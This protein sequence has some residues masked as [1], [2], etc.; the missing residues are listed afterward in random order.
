MRSQVEE[1]SKLVTVA[2]KLRMCF[3]ADPDVS[4]TYV[5]QFGSTFV[6]GSRA[7]SRATKRELGSS[8]ENLNILQFYY[9]A[10]MQIE[11]I[12]FWGDQNGTCSTHK[13]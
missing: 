10:G 6:K 1:I 2:P 12:T 7:F 3:E 4:R 9:F 8:T 11:V 13:H 5:E